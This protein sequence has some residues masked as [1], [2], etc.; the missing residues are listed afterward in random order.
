RAAAVRWT[1]L[2]GDVSV[3]WALA[4]HDE[5]EATAQLRRQLRTLGR[6]SPGGV[7]VDGQAVDVAHALVSHL[8]RL[9]R[10]GRDD[11]SL[12]LIVDDPFVDLAEPTRI[13]LLELVQR[14]SGP[15]QVI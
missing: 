4:H 14:T 9:R 13:E 15:P 2:A 11:E 10:A 7:D 8:A 3:E 6:V 12:P 5:I 1:T